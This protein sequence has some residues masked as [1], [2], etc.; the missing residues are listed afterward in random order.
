MDRAKEKEEYH[1]E[2]FFT[3]DLNPYVDGR[4]KLKF[5]DR[6]IN[7]EKHTGPLWQMSNKFK[8]KR[9]FDEIKKVHLV[10]TNP[11]PDNWMIF[12]PKWKE[13][14]EE[15]W[16]SNRKFQI[17]NYISTRNSRINSSCA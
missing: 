14:E 16:M 9:I 5:G 13:D 10:D 6:E 12:R 4:E 2:I 8:S 15:K 3:K 11:Y 17:V 1:R 7:F